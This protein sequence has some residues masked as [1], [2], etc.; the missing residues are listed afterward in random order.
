[1]DL[2]VGLSSDPREIALSGKKE[3]VTLLE[4]FHFANPIEGDTPVDRFGVKPYRSDDF[5]GIQGEE[6][7]SACAKAGDNPLA[8]PFIGTR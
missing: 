5:F 6:R 8:Y 1:M 7:V 4:K 2:V 3:I